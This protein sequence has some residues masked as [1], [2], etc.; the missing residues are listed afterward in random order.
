MMDTYKLLT[1]WVT[2]LYGI[3]W[4]FGR[5]LAGALHC[6][7]HPCARTGRRHGGRRRRA[8]SR[9]V[10]TTIDLLP[11]S[12]APPPKPNFLLVCFKLHQPPTVSPK[13]S[14]IRT[15]MLHL[16]RALTQ[17]SMLTCR[18]LTVNGASFNLSMKQ[19]P[20]AFRWWRVCSV[21][22]YSVLDVNSRY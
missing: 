16:L 17:K 3:P 9:R 6:R 7:S 11:S 14:R 5:T 4:V 12:T 20:H 10:D 2:P 8:Y 15:L 21:G 1:R 18:Y 22:S 13:N 19:A